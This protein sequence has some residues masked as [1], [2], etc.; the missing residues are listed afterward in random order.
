MKYECPSCFLS[1]SDSLQPV[2]N[3]FFPLCKF[4][5]LPH[6]QKDLLNWQIQHLENI[7]KE[8]LIYIFR[9]F[10]RYFINELDVLKEK[11][12]DKSKD[13][14]NSGGRGF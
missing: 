5:S 7:N 9:N 14:T 10:Y 1:W 8:K 12:Y 13:D 11:F 3:I 6:E 2:D 4:C